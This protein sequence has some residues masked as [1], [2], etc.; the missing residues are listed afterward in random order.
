ME[1]K[2]KWIANMKFVG[3]D[4]LGHTVLMDTRP[5]VG[6]EN[7]ASTPMD[8]LLIALGGCTG[9]DIVSILR[10]MKIEFKS[11]EI[12]IRGERASEPPRVYRKI[13]LVYK[14]KGNNIPNDKVKKAVKLSQEKYCSISAMLRPTVEI[15]YTVEIK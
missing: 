7:S 5:E 12:E 13:E 3:E 6:G 14:V 4:T 1:A 11:V 10:K 9:M 2:V 15:S 8:L